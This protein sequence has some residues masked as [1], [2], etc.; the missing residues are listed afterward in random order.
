MRSKSLRLHTNYQ[1][2]RLQ[3]SRWHLQRCVARGPSAKTS[4][5]TISLDLGFGQIFRGPPAHKKELRVSRLQQ[6]SLVIRPLEAN[7]QWL[8]GKSEVREVHFQRG[9]LQ[10]GRQGPSDADASEHSM[11]YL[12]FFFST[13]L[14]RRQH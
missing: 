3:R 9:P 14:T 4:V 5:T 10:A 7:D 13:R 1:T 12:P 11:P 8:N 6:G 2:A